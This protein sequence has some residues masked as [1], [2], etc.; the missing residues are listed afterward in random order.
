MVA[1]FTLNK[2]PK[3]GAVVC[4][5]AA[6]VQIRKSW[7]TEVNTVCVCVI[8]FFCLFLFFYYTSNFQTISRTGA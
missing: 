1:S 5:M 3:S 4:L 2:L 7:V 8:V 6:V